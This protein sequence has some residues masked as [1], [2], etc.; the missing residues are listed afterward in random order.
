MGPRMIWGKRDELVAGSRRRLHGAEIGTVE[1]TVR[2]WHRFY[3]VYPLIF[4]AAPAL[5]TLVLLVPSY[6]VAVENEEIAVLRRML[7]ELKAEN[8]KLSQRLGA[9]EGASATRRTGPAVVHERPA[10]AATAAQ[11]AP[12]VLSPPV[13]PPA[14]PAPDLS[15]A[16]AKRPLNERVKELEIGWAAQENATRQ[17]IRDTLSKT[18]PKINNFLALSGVVEGLASRTGEFNG[19]TKENLALSTAEIAFAIKLSDWLTGSLVLH[20]DNGAGAIFPTGNS[21]VVPTTPGLGVDRFTLDRTHISIGDLMQ[22]TIAARC[23][24]EALH[25]GRS[26]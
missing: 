10:P 16:A 3:S 5:F 11:R 1:S 9:L 7:G 14:L 12:T 4:R 26:Q 24:V 23:G 19:P 17:I 21:P 6:A 8:R 20:F 18:G 13:D 22:F 15:E 25:F 2:S